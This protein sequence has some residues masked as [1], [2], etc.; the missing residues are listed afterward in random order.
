MTMLV[1]AADAGIDPDFSR[2]LTDSPFNAFDRKA[3]MTFII[4]SRD[5]VLNVTNLLG[6]GRSIV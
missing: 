4:S 1:L 6:M 2:D 5:D 3:S